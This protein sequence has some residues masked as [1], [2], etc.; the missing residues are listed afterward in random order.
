MDFPR[1]SIIVPVYNGQ[2]TLEDCIKSL[3]EIEYDKDK[4]EIIVV[5]NCSTDSTK[6]ILERYQSEI[7]ILQEVKK[8]ASAARNKGIT[9]A[10]GEVIAF[11]D[12]DCVAD[13]DWLKNLAISATEE[14][15]GIVGGKI[16]ALNS[17]SIIA[18]AGEKIHDHRRAFSDDIP[19]AISMNW[20]SRKEVLIEVGLFDEDFLRSQD[21]DLSLRIFA[22]GYK[23]VYSENAIIYHKN[24]DT[25][26]DLFYKG[27]LGGLYATK[28]Y[29]KHSLFYKKRGVENN[30]LKRFISLVIYIK[31]IL[32]NET[33]RDSVF[34]IIHYIGRVCGLAIGSFRFMHARIGY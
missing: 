1:A 9:A 32:K 7:I 17:K 3:L 30:K 26:R 28:L 12:V 13:K 33:L 14:K 10:K 23:F 15:V 27:Y 5:D 11:T 25:Y 21:T 4:L 24:S 22:A 16:L 31:E 18:K 6:D 34:I 2:A 19:H 8:G 29:K 20:A